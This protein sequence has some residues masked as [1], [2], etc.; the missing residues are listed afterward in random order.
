MVDMGKPNKGTK[1]DRRLKE[2][3]KKKKSKK[4][5]AKTKSADGRFPI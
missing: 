5:F 1:K 4:P 3:K 2:N